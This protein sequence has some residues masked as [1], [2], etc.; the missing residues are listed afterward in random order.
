ME[1]SAQQ[2]LTAVTAKHYC[3]SKRPLLKRIHVTSRCQRKDRDLIYAL[4]YEKRKRLCK[5]TVSALFTVEKSLF[6][7]LKT[8]RIMTD[9]SRR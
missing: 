1:D 2:F 5:Q 3:N 4:F 6:K 8:A 9:L 7:R